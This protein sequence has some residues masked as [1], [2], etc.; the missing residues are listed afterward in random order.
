MN[1]IPLILLIL[2]AYLMPFAGGPQQL[3]ITDC[4]MVGEAAVCETARGPITA[5]W[6]DLDTVVISMYRS[7]SD[8]SHEV[9]AINVSV[10]PK[11][12]KV[13]GGPDLAFELVE[14]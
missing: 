4:Y 11:V 2:Q 1:V 14:Y 3:D 7:E 12:C 13:G 5:E 9:A 8:P 10:P 6:A